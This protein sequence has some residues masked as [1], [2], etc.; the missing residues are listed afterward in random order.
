V[1]ARP[2]DADLMPT[3]DQLWRRENH[4]LT[5]T[6]GGFVEGLWKGEDDAEAEGCCGVNGRRE[7]EKWGVA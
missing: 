3:G 1:F 7:I 4:C 5:W 6:L 2:L